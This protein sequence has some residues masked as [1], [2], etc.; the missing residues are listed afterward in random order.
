MT[1]YLSYLACCSLPMALK[2]TPTRFGT[3][4]LGPCAVGL[5]GRE[6]T[7][8]DAVHRDAVT[9]ACDTQHCSGISWPWHDKQPAGDA[10]GRR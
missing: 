7:G 9:S 6:R 1:Q 2:T 10:G 5:G 3:D 4:P 8:A